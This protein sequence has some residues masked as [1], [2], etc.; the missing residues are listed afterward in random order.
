MISPVIHGG[1]GAW[2][3][4]ARKTALRICYPSTG[5]I[6]SRQPELVTVGYNAGGSTYGISYMASQ[7]SDCASVDLLLCAAGDPARG[8]RH[9]CHAIHP[10][11]GWN[12]GVM[13]MGAGHGAHYYDES[14]TRQFYMVK[15]LLQAGVM[16][17]GIGMPGYGFSV[18]PMSLVSDSGAIATL[19]QVHDLTSVNAAGIPALPLFIDPYFVALNWVLTTYGAQVLRVGCT[20]HS[21]GG[22]STIWAG[23][24]DPRMTRL[25][26]VT[27]Y[28]PLTMTASRDDEQ[29][30]NFPPLAAI[31]RT[32]GGYLRDYDVLECMAAFES[33]RKLFHLANL[34]DVIFT[35]QGHTAEAADRLVWVRKQIHGTITFSAG[36][37]GSAGTGNGHLYT[38]AMIETIATDFLA[39]L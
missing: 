24:L 1:G 14:N 18:N 12:G 6:P 31:I 2:P 25:Y 22:W 17:I 34:D 36:T 38:D 20:G 4:T 39:G 7:S 10:S 29:F 3:L 30:A 35:Y 23:A 37:G 15:R 8:G 28:A 33:N 19:P 5:A 11:A 13:L 26:P 9:P 16:V 27:G 32:A 21:G